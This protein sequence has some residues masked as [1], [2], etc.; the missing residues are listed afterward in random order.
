MNA[1]LAL[2]EERAQLGVLEFAE[3]MQAIRDQS[4]YPGARVKP[5]AWKTYCNERWSMSKSTV[6]GIIQSLPVLRRLMSDGVGLELAPSAAARIAAL[7]IAVQDAILEI[8]TNRDE[9]SKRA[10]N[11]R[12]AIRQAEGEGREATIEELI[13]AAQQPV[14]KKKKSKPKY[15]SKFISLFT[16]GLHLI[17]EAADYAQENDLDPTENDWGWN[18]VEKL[19]YQTDRIAE[20]IHRPAHLR[21]MDEE[22]EKLLAEEV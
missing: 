1:E 18:R 21:D 7:P 2:H 3:A 9:I 11:V 14:K 10:N 22:L 12:K 8:T 6:E 15:D 13:A 5:D 16:E 4:L 20:R 19:R 17:K